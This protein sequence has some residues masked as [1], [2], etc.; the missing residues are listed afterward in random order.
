MPLHDVPGYVVEA[1]S[2][3]ESLPDP[4]T[5][6][7]RTHLLVNSHTA[8]AV[9][10]SVG[11]TPFQSGGVNAATLTIVRGNAVQIQSDGTRWVTKSS[12]G[13]AFFAATGVSN[14]A[15]DVVFA[16]PVGLFAAAPVVDLAF[17]GAASAS[18]VDFRITALSATSC[19]VNVRQS[20]ATVV[21]LVGLTLLAASAPL[22]GATIHLIATPAGSTP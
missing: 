12:N 17:Q 4:T 2:A 18:P 16:F 13:R 15:G 8:S 22:N 7:G 5:V 11:P 20:L 21:A 3:A 10:S 1:Y 6:N 19:T 9:W 14:A